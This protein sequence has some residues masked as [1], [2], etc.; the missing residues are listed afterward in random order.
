MKKTIVGLAVILMTALAVNAQ[1]PD[2]TMQQPHHKK[3]RQ[4]GHGMMAK[5]L[6]FSDLQKDQLKNIKSDYHKKVSELKK[7]DE[8]TVKEMNTRMK[9]LQQ[10]QK[11]S[12][13]ALLTPEQKDL[14]AHIIEEN[15]Y[16]EPVY[17]ID[18]WLYQIGT[19]KVNPSTTDEAKTSVKDDSARF[20]QLLSKAQGKLQSA[21]NLVRAKSED[22]LIAEDS[23]KNKF[24]VIFQHEALAGFS[25]VKSCFS[26]SQKRDH[27]R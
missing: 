3:F 6:N 9:T 14:F 17:Y 21:E 20:Q 27:G 5:K 15:I 22:R 10:E 12:V 26:D 8:I 16:R 13:Q 4:H 19:G 25:G 24:E 1:Q 7:H 18:E 2:K 11:S 23:L